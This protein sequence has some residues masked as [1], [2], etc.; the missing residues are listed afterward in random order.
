VSLAWLRKRGITAIPKASSVD[1]LRDNWA[2]LSLQL[3]EGELE[4]IDGHDEGWRMVDPGVG[5]WN[6]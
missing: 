1:H 5:P 2:S 4:R 3:D 6:R